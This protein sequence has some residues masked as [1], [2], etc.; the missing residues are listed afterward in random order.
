VG[1]VDT[2]DE[3]PFTVPILVLSLDS[4]FLEEEGGP[5]TPGVALRITYSAIPIPHPPSGIAVRQ[6][7]DRR[8]RG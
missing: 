3:G 5:D 1:T 2:S 4:S 7:C 8:S 6:R